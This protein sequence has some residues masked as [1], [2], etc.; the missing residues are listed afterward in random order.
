MLIDEFVDLRV[1]VGETD[2]LA[3][4]REQARQAEERGTWLRSVVVRGRRRG[5]TARVESAGVESAQVESARV[6]SAQAV[7]AQD[8]S[9]PVGAAA[10]GPL[11]DPAGAAAEPARE[12]AH[13]AR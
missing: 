9:A 11:A 5:A 10:D 7:P 1:R 2:R 12:L 3:R 8:A 4:E 6:E 13:A